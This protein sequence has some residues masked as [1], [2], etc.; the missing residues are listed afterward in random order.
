MGASSTS[1]KPGTSG[2]PNGKPKSHPE[3]RL[4]IVLALPKAVEKLVALLDSPDPDDVRFACKT[5]L[6]FGLAKPTPTIGTDEA[7]KLAMI[8]DLLSRSP[9]A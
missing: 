7:E 9:E 8:A 2:N 3:V 6:D 5:L 1:F 4:A